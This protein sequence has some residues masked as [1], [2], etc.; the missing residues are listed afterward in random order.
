VL[1]LLLYFFFFSPS[2]LPIARSEAE[3]STAA[4]PDH[5]A[6]PSS[7]VH[8]DLQ[9][10][11]TRLEMQHLTERVSDLKVY[12]SAMALQLAK[13]ESSTE[14]RQRRLERLHEEL[15]KITAEQEEELSLQEVGRRVA[16]GAR[17][18]IYY[19]R[20]INT[21]Y[22]VP[23]TAETTLLHTTA[24]SMSSCPL[25]LYGISCLQNCVGHSTPPRDDS[26][27]TFLKLC[28]P[29]FQ[30]SFEEGAVMSPFF[31]DEPCLVERSTDEETVLAAAGSVSPPPTSSTSSPQTSSFTADGHVCEVQCRNAAC[32]YWHRDQL[33]HMKMT[34][35]FLV[36][37]LEDAC[38]R[39][40]QRC[41]VRQLLSR[42]AR[43]VHHADSVSLVCAVMCETLQTLIGLGLCS[44][45]SEG[46]KL[47]HCVGAP[48]L[49]RSNAT[50]LLLSGNADRGQVPAVGEPL[51][52]S[53]AA[54]D[55][56]PTALETFQQNRNDR[57]WRCL[58][59]CVPD[60]AQRHWLARQGIQLFPRS[61]QL[62]LECVVSCLQC[63]AALEEVVEACRSSCRTLSAQAAAAVVAGLDGG[64][65][66]TTVARHVGYMVALVLVHCAKTSAEAG[67]QFVSPLLS[68]DAEAGLPVL[69]LPVARQNLALMSVALRRGGHLRGVEHLP[70]A[71]V[72]DQVFELANPDGANPEVSG[73]D[74]IYAS[75]RFI[76]AFKRDHF[77][78]MLTAACA[79]ALQL[80]LLR[81]FSHR[82][83]YLERVA[84]K[85]IPES[86]LAQGA[87]Y[88]T[89]VNTVAQQQ[90]VAAA[91]QV[92]EALTATEGA[93]CFLNLLLSA[94]L[95]V[96]GLA[97]QLNAER[98][99][100]QLCAGEQLPVETLDCA[101]S[102]RKAAAAHGEVS[103]L[104]WVAAY[105]LRLR[106]NNSA[107]EQKAQRADRSAETM[108][109]PTAA[110]KGGGEA[111]WV[112]L[113]AF[114][115]EVLA[116]DTAAAALY[117]TLLLQ[118]SGEHHNALWFYTAVRRCLGYFREVHVRTWD[119]SDAAYATMV[120][121]PHY[122]SLRIYAEVPLLLGDAAKDT[123][124]WRRL[125]LTAA[126][127][128][129]VLHPLLVSD[130]SAV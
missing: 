81:T 103:A 24:L 12:Q 122:M 26:V 127:E 66:G 19:Q 118:H 6:I 93:T 58:L 105:A 92:A 129:G 25:S 49:Q 73:R 20:G 94:Q 8:V 56:L 64:Q 16:D 116:A 10:L 59:A 125:V 75:F 43:N 50:A 48:L 44:V 29:L 126:A 32:A 72:S 104:E 65:Y 106:C 28:A 40:E 7:W 77:D 14:K 119:P 3:M 23:S 5:L 86:A 55:A 98:A 9:K 35:H 114:P 17:S 99:V 1:S 107:E 36:L 51:S 4:A 46:K 11:R 62:H 45:L 115:V 69:L 84:E 61:P 33:A 52:S 27:V 85:T 74:V 90:S 76:N 47:H 82:L 83:S 68:I 34:A 111:E 109:T 96:W 88:A 30:W 123:F 101:E 100:T 41:C 31:F 57:S 120:G 54:T 22:F 38:V 89:Y 53:R 95:R 71:A 80:S 39:S 15:R 78:L 13:L 37:S 113:L 128:L 112:A 117:F 2:K 121:L 42:L 97:S 60:A 91:V 87:V 70:L 130:P 79:G 21:S 18:Q 67:L 124:E 110:E 108:V 63:G 102:V